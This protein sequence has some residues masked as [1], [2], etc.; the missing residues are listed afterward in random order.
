MMDLMT[1]DTTGQGTQDV[2]RVLRPPA[3]EAPT[4][5]VPY[6]ADF[7]LPE[8]GQGTYTHEQDVPRPDPQDTPALTQG[9]AAGVPQDTE[10]VPQDTPQD[11]RKVS[12]WRPSALLN[13]ARDAWNDHQDSVRSTQDALRAAQRRAAQDEQAARDALSRESAVRRRRAAR[14]QPGA[15]TIAPIPHWMEIL[16]VWGERLGGTALKISPLVVSGYFT[17][18]V[19]RDA[20]LLMDG[21]VAF[22]LVGGLE[23]SVWYLN[24][25][26]EKFKLE[27]DSTLSITLAIF[28]IIGLI[29]AMIGGHAIWKSAGRVPIW[30]DLPGTD[31][32]VPLAEVVPAIAVA[33]MSA[34][35]AFIWAKEATYK[36]RAKL[37]E[38]GQIDPRAPK[39]SAGAWVFTWWESICSLKHAFKYRVTTRPTD[40][41]RHWKA[42]GKPAIWPVPDGFRWDGKSKR[43]IAV[44]LDELRDIAERDALLAAI[45]GHRE[46][47]Q[48]VPAITGHPRTGR[49]ALPAAPTRNSSTGHG[50]VSN[51]TSPTASGTQ[52]TGHHG[53]QDSPGGQ[54]TSGSA[55]GAYGTDPT[56]AHGTQGGQGT[57]DGNGTGERDTVDLDARLLKHADKALI[58][59]EMFDGKYGRPHWRTAERPPSVRAINTAIDSWR[60]ENEGPDAGFNSKEI[61]SQVQKLIIRLRETPELIDLVKVQAEVDEPTSS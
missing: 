56:G 24:R 22:F 3:P 45:T 53:A 9:T 55:A 7:W 25:L 49:P 6:P 28:G 50:A 14:P 15:D 19:G 61:A 46:P 60:K 12:R 44:P 41:W 23:G 21:L 59:I 30:I 43:M 2:G 8:T 52:G 42:A 13:R 16:Q 47:P 54:D 34:I 33:L 1:P 11:A 10:T 29:A 48:D 27:N 58:V 40:D 35:G 57:R 26:R 36:H 18:D 17:Y 4:T 38:L 20:P 51:G 32:R 37:R 5:G 39:I 31:N